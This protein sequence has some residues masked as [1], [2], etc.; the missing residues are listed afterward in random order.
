MQREEIVKH[1]DL[2]AIQELAVTY[3]KQ[4]KINKKNALE[5]ARINSWEE[6]KFNSDGSFQELIGLFPDGSPM[7]YAI[8]NATAAISTRTNYLINS[9][10][11]TG[12]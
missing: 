2:M 9:Y 6:F 1:Y 11:L 12:N 7:Y 4:A 5:A 3:E 10:G 8:D